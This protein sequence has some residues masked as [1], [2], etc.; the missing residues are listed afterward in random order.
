MD[1]FYW[2][3]LIVLAT[4]PIYSNAYQ[5][6]A[7]VNMIVC[8]VKMLPSSAQVLFISEVIVILIFQYNPPVV[9]NNSSCANGQLRL[10]GGEET[11]RGRVEVCLSNQW[12]TICNHDW[13]DTD[14]AVVCRQLGLDSDSKHTR[15]N[16]AN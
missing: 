13:D 1:L 3:R 15:F 7:M 2:T 11:D 8:T 6:V 9:G 4:S 12:G 5:L 16:T 14:A 10:V